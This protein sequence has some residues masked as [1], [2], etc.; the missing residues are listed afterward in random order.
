MKSFALGFV[1]CLAAAGCSKGASRA[2]AAYRFLPANP[3]L[4][5]RL[6][7]PRVRAWPQYAKVADKALAGVHQVLATAKERCGLDLLGEASSVIVAKRGALLAGDLTV[8]AGGLARDKVT[9][10]LAKVADSGSV[11]LAVDGDLVQATLDGRSIASG[12][13]LPS[14]EV[15]LVTR[16]GHGVAADA[17]KTEVAHGAGAPPAWVAELDATAPIA[18]R[19]S[20]ATRTVVADVKLADPLVARAKIT[21]PTAEAAKHDVAALR[22]ITSYLQ[23]GKA[24]T[25]RVEPQ[26]TAT[27][28]DLTSKGAQIDTLISIALPALFPPPPPPPPPPPSIDPNAP[29]VDCASLGPA[30]KTYLEQNVAA[31]GRANAAAQM[32]KLVPALQQA[33]ISS[34]TTDH[35]A[36]AAIAC[37]VQKASAITEFEKCRQMLPDDQRARFDQAV[38]AALRAR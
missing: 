23:Q 35:W 25:M 17:W 27:F 9:G 5:V 19:T 33:F 15:V 29:P 36:Q 30:V 37:H 4:V 3:E 11:K 14:G 18:V 16:D 21:S 7:L 32:E 28:V 13:I 20:D 12:A 2:P 10:C 22:A 38:A 24:G 34:C 31:S 8:I 1:A 6:D 26:G